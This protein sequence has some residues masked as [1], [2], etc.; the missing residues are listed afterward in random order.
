MKVTTYTSEYGMTQICFT[1]ESTGRKAWI[2]RFKGERT[3]AARGAD[4]ITWAKEY[5]KP[6][7]L[8]NGPKEQFIKST[9][10]ELATQFVETGRTYL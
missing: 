2:T 6:I 9:A 5:T 4:Y 8:H 1:D 7:T 3:W 10:I